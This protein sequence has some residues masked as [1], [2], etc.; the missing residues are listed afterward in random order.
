[1]TAKGIAVLRKKYAHVANMDP[2]QLQEFDTEL[3]NYISVQRSAIRRTFKERA[4]E[5]ISPAFKEAV[6]MHEV[7]TERIRALR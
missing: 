3:I 1:M 2:R 6:D 7:V 5:E 4:I